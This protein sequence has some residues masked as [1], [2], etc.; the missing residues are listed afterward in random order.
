MKFLVVTDLHQNE[1]NIPGIN[2]VLKDEGIDTVLFLGDITD[3]GTGK[4][5][6][7]IV[8][9]IEAKCY[10][11]PGNCDSRDLPECISSV[12][13]DMHGKKT[14]IDGITVVGLGGSNPTI[15][16]TPFELSEEEIESKLEAVSENGMLLMTH[17]PAF[18]TLDH[19]PNGMSV[20]STAIAK[21]IEKYKPVVAL[22]GHIH[23]DIGVFSKDGTMFMNPGPAREGYY[24]ILT[25]ENGKPEGKLCKLSN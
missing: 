10:A 3:M 18:G 25:I 11:L 15:F 9:K 1:K 23:E 21:I 22:S 14:V 7:E 6:A 5:A 13:T 4:K 19:I 8:S 12:A 24:G 17:A 2:A 20:G 16:N